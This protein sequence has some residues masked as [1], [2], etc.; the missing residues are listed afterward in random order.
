M[1]KKSNYLVMYIMNFSLSIWKFHNFVT[2]LFNP[3]YSSVGK[4]VFFETIRKEVFDCLIGECNFF[5]AIGIM[6]FYLLAVIT[7]KDSSSDLH[8]HSPCKCGLEARPKTFCSAE[9][10]LDHWTGNCLMVTK[11]I[12]TCIWKYH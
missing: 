11:Q 4:D 3:N 5:C 10:I 7:K 12:N 8:I 9:G 2:I 6:F 1:K